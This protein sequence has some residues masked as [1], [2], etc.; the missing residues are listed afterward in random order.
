MLAYNVV[1]YYYSKQNLIMRLNRYI[2]YEELKYGKSKGTQKEYK[3]GMSIIA[4]GIGNAKFL[5]GYKKRFSLNL[6]EH[7]YY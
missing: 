6:Q 3:K 2:K 5:D 4:K 1:K 7:T